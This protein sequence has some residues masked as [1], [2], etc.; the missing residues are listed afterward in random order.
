MYEMSRYNS[1]GSCLVFITI[2]EGSLDACPRS[3]F[4]GLVDCVQEGV[5]GELGLRGREREEYFFFSVVAP[6]GYGDFPGY[7]PSVFR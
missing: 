3:T 1:A 4:R 7:F 6:E 5:G 2:G